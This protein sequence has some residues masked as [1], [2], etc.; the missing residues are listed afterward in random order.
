MEVLLSI[1]RLCKAKQDL[2]G[3]CYPPNQHNCN[4]DKAWALVTPSVQDTVDIQQLS[5]A[6]VKK[7]GPLERDTRVVFTQAHMGC[8]L[9]GKDRR[10]SVILWKPVR[11]FK[12]L[13]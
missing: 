11:L 9:L 2:P 4:A 13:P 8:C 6:S 1:W 3:F 5:E 10:I 12:R 7:T